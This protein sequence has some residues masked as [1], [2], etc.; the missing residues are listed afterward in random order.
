MKALESHNQLKKEAYEKAKVAFEAQ[1]KEDGVKNLF[2]NTG[3]QRAKGFGS[4]G[5]G[6]MNA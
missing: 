1:Q 2:A 3:P 4:K 6:K 5:A